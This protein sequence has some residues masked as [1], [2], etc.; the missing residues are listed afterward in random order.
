MTVLAWYYRMN[1]VENMGAL[2]LQAMGGAKQIPWRQWPSTISVWKDQDNNQCADPKLVDAHCAAKTE[3]RT[4]KAGN[5]S[6]R[7]ISPAFKLLCSALG[8]TGR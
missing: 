1:V 7:Y 5:Y 2:F 8:L 3:N 6:R 4:A